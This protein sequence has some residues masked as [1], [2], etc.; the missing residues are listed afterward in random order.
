MGLE[1][2]AQD[3]NNN[4]YPTQVYGVVGQYEKSA[5]G[6]MVAGSVA[7]NTYQI[8]ATYD[9]ADLPATLTGPADS[10]ATIPA[11][12]YIESCAVKVLSTISGGTSLNVG[13][14]QPDGTVIDAAGL[15]SGST[16]TSGHITGGGADIDTA[17]ATEAQLTVGG[18][19]TAGVIQVTVSYK[20]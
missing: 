19:R 8:E 2:K 4:G 11:N 18:T 9:L 1:R 14:S 6:G 17:T 13:L 12:A 7:K 5:K 16:A 20:I 15:V 10:V 3:S